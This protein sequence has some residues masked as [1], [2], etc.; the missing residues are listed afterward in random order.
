MRF[1]LKMKHWQLFLMTWGAP[2]LL[3]FFSFANPRLTFQLFPIMMLI[4]LVGTFGWVWA[5][6][7]QLN[8]K[9]PE[10]VKL[11]V[12]RFKFL[13]AIP[14]VYVL[15]V[16]LVMGLSPALGHAMEGIHPALIAAIVLPLHLSSIIIIFWGIRFAAKTLK[17]VELGRT[18]RFNDYIGEFFLIWFSI[19]GYWILQPKLNKLIEE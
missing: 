5:I 9:L 18:A 12:N 6:A 11:N 3:N 7:T 10:E 1:L 2:L 13:F 19:I 16:L 15:L 14:N 4:F 17:S 8:A